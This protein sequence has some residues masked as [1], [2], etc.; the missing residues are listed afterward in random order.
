MQKLQ[1]PLFNREVGFLD[2]V[3]VDES[4]HLIVFSEVLSQATM[5]WNSSFFSV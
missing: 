4:K 1:S 5:S 2:D 3:S